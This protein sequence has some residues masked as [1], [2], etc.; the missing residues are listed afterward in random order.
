MIGN[1]RSYPFRICAIGACLALAPGC[2]SD[3]ASPREDSPGRCDNGADD[4]GDGYVD[5][6][7]QDCRQ[8]AVCVN[9][10][11]GDADADGDSDADGDTDADGDADGEECNG[12]DDD[13]DNLIDEGD[14]GS[15]VACLTGLQSGCAQG[16]TTCVAGEVACAPE[17][18][19]QPET[20]ANPGVDDNCDGE[21]EDVDFVGDACETG[22]AGPCSPGVYACD[23]VSLVCEPLVVAEE[24]NCPNEVDD[25]CDGIV[26]D[27][28][29]PQPEDCGTPV[30]DDNCDGW[31]DNAQHVGNGCESGR[32]GVCWEARWVCEGPDLVCL[33]YHEPSREVCDTWGDEDC[34]GEVDEADCINPNLH[35]TGYGAE[36]TDESRTGTYNRQQALDACWL[37]VAISGGICDE[38]NCSCEG[39]QDLSACVK[40]I[41]D[42]LGFR[43]WFYQGPLMGL[44]TQEPDM[45]EGGVPWD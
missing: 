45:C 24:R 37:D 30:Y 27:T 16:R 20:C 36:W 1:R 23:G 21:T 6:D 8:F 39:G 11:D 13:G 44:T 25:D 40:S 7:D 35:H 15:G 28:A 2:G 34:D 5:C 38:W 43:Y 41:I 22:I 18:E 29:G 17:V 31:V 42:G 19:P 26:D 10:G 9:G 12:L 3:S 32:F 33:S 4:D 14:P